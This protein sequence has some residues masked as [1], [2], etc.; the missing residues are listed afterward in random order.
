MKVL[1]SLLFVVVL[2]CGTALGKQQCPKKNGTSQISGDVFHQYEATV[3]LTSGGKYPSYQLLSKVC[4]QAVSQCR[5]TCES[6]NRCAAW[7]L[8]NSGSSGGGSVYCSLYE[9]NV[10]S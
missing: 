2:L 7:F 4:K 5:R 3:R 10:H 6:T 9:K 8:K 1:V